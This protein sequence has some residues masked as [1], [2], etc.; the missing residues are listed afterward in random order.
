MRHEYYKITRDIFQGLKTTVRFILVIVLPMLDI[1]C[2]NKLVDSSKA[3]TVSATIDLQFGFAGHWV[4]ISINSEERYDARLSREVPFTGPEAS[5]TFDVV[6]GLTTLIVRWQS[7]DPGD[8]VPPI[9]GDTAIFALGDSEAYYIGLGIVD[10][11]LHI[12]VQDTPFL[13]L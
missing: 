10:D 8:S 11:S 3:E 7:L 6:R 5:F 4:E 12:T 9:E 13:Y 2:E 1:G